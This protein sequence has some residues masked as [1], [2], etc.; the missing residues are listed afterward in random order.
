M[1]CHTV[2]EASPVS[3]WKQP[4]SSRVNDK[5]KPRKD[6]FFNVAREKWFLWV[7]IFKIKFFGSTYNNVTLLNIIRVLA[8]AY[9][10][11]LLL[12][13]PFTNITYK[14]KVQ[15]FSSE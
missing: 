14:D 6:L 2:Q 5:A 4:K 9:I 15:F 13:I 10:A 3:G 7:A 11:L 12:S 8:S 1:T